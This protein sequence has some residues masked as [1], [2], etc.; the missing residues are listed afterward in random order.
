[1]FARMAHFEG[2]TST[3]IDSEIEMLRKDIESFNRGV[4]G[5]YAPSGLHQVVK[6]MEMLVNREHGTVAFT[7]YCDTE[8]DIR[9]ADRILR[10]MSPK[11]SGWGRRVSAEIYEVALEETLSLRR[12]A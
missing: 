12:A 6:R 7:V 9:E 11:S 4:T 2:G 3:D 5:T 10:E 1:M 8:A